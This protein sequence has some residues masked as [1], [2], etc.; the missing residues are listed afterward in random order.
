MCLAFNAVFSEI[1][2]FENYK[3]TSLQHINLQVFVLRT[4]G[5]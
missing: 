2:E 3:Y 5:S 1:A 4:F